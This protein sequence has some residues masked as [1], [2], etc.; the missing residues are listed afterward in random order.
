MTAVAALVPLNYYLVLGTL[1]FGIGLFG[2]LKRTN[3][4]MILMSIELMLNAVNI[5][6]VAFARYLTPDPTPGFIF[7][8]FII[9]VAAAE[10]AVGLAIVLMIVR[11]QGIIDIN[12]INLLKG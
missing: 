1:L 12:R 7:A 4:I 3:A 11:R 10:A 5:N 8:I 2:A 6:L 9:T